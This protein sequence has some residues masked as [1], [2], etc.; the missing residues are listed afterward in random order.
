M[1]REEKA[2]FIWNIFK[3]II[4]IIL[5]VACYY[6][7][8]SHPAEQIALYSWVKNIVQKVEIFW[9]NITGR[10]WNLLARKFDLESKYLE[11]IHFAE[12]KWCINQDFVAELHQRYKTLQEEDNS[13]IENYITSY[14]ISAAEFEM[15]IYNDCG[16]NE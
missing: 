11:M 7:L 1:N 2:T 4:W 13:K 9:Y 3:L 6:Y 14:T 10:D 5:L 16:K 12:E 8:E 15:K